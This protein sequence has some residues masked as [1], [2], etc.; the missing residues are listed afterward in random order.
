[1]TLRSVLGASLLVATSL[2]C[3]SKQ[4]AQYPSTKGMTPSEARDMYNAAHER[5]AVAYERTLA[6]RERLWTKAEE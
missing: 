4:P 3:S 5:Q 6:E 2:A 1:M